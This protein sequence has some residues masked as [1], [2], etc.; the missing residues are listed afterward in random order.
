ME[1]DATSS[2]TKEEKSA[3]ASKNIPDPR[4]EKVAGTEGGFSKKSRKHK[5]RKH[6][7]KKSMLKTRK[8]R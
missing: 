7:T 1:T 4:F 3:F 8:V 6:R 5:R 2:M